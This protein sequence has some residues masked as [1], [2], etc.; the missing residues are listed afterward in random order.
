M[1][2]SHPSHCT[3]MQVAGGRTAGLDFHLAHLDAV[4]RE[5]FGAGGQAVDGGPVRPGSDTAGCG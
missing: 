2:L 3:V 1:D 4:P 5:L